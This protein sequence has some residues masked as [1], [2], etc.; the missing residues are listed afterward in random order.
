MIRR[1]SIKKPPTEAEKERGREVLFS[2]K[3]LMNVLFALL[4]FQA[5]LIL[6]RPEDPELEYYTLTQIFEG[7]I[8]KLMV[9]LIGLVLIVIYWIQINKQL[10]NLVRSSMFH[11]GVGVA[12]M[13]CLMLYLYFVRFDMEF[14]GLIIALQMQSIFLALAGFLG[15][16]NWVYARKHKLTSNQINDKEE[17]SMFFQLLPEPSAALFAL[18]FA[19]ISPEAWSLSFLIIFPLT[20]VCNKLAK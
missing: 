11:A 10:G 19:S 7:N 6:P 5:F 1:K 9:M 12:Q 18:P 16:F 3:V 14:E 2:L 20:F 13:I 4:I 15:V 8:D 17:K